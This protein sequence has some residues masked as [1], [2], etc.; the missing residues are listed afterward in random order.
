MFLPGG[1]I[2]PAFY[3]QCA[4]ELIDRLFIAEVLIANVVKACDVF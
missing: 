2:I 3:E 4:A 1:I